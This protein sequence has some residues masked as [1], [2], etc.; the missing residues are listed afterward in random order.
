MDVPAANTL[1]Q[2]VEEQRTP[3]QEVKPQTFEQLHQIFW[4]QQV[5]QNDGDKEDS[6]FIFIWFNMTFLRRVW[7][8][9]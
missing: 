3:F 1:S 4:E 6:K 2:E 9:S 7:I 5:S 8:F